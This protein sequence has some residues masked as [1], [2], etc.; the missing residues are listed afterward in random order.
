MNYINDLIRRYPIL[1]KNEKELNQALEILI[2]TVNNKGTIYA[3][4]NGGSFSDSQHLA[5]ELLKS[6]NKKRPVL[7]EQKEKLIS[8]F[9]DQGKFLADKLE[10]GISATALGCHDAY[11]TAFANDVDADL[12]FAQELFARANK[13]DTLL[14]LSSS[15][16]SKNVKYAAMVAQ[17]FGIKV[18]LLSGKSVG[19]IAEY[20]D[21]SIHVD[22]YETYKIQELSL[23]IYHALCLALEDNRF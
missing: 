7:D 20:S 18:I 4:G 9:N 17:F 2:N 12:I 23:P 19:T 21:C 14:C 8:M 1:K 13:N 3:C 5:G 15:G 22:E 10:R 6:F 11:L 16:N